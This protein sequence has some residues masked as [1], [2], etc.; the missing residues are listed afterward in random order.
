MTTKPMPM[1]MD[2][3][4][5]SLRIHNF[6]SH[7]DAWGMATD[8]PPRKIINK[9]AND[10]TENDATCP[11]SMASLPFLSSMDT[12]TYGNINKHNKNEIIPVKIYLPV[13]LALPNVS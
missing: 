1:T 12:N 10:N 7:R 4:L 3:Y 13:H 8:K 5:F 9:G 2:K 6:S 11:D